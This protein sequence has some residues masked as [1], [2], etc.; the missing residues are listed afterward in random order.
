LGV[1]IVEWNE[2]SHFVAVNGD[3]AVRVEIVFVFDPKTGSIELLNA[4]IVEDADS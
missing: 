4:E 3:H 1:Q 2:D